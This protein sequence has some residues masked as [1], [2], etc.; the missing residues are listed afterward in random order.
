MKLQIRKFDYKWVV[1]IVCFL[2]N[3]VCLGFT[4]HRSLYLDAITK[5][6][7]FERSL[8]ALNETFRYTT[9]AVIN[10][11]FGGLLQRIGARK[12]IAGG[13][14]ML[15]ASMV[16]A[17]WAETVAMFYV[18]GILLGIGYACTTTT[19]TGSI[20]RRWFKKD[21]GRYTGI[22]LAAN[23]IG[24]A[25]S[26]QI[27]SPLISDEANPFG[28]RNAYLISAVFI[29]VAGI[30]VLIFLRER[31][32]NEELEVVTTG[33]KRR[34][35]SWEGIPL[36]TALRRPY[37]YV[38]AVIVF[39]TGFMLQ[40]I[41]GVYGTHLKD[42]GFDAGVVATIASVYS[43]TLTISKITVGILYDR[44]GL[45]FVMVLCQGSAAISLV[46]LVVLAVTPLGTAM[47][48][49]FAVLYAL[50]LP[51]E[52]LVIPLIVSELFG[53]ASFDK[54]F[55]VFAALNYAGYAVSAP[56]VNLCFDLTDSYNLIFLLFSGL[57]VVVAVI[58]QLVIGTAHKERR[59]LE[60]AKQ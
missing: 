39:L 32:K 49:V 37:F 52:T 5:A 28:Y 34:G 22:A 33:K 38:A 17:A 43:L 16:V 45:R 19:I 40:G 23:G 53:S 2:M 51:L 27:I 31:P 13:F 60:A 42:V 8:F 29:A 57:T 6:L 56:I 24:G 15:F 3:F 48:F 36:K 7:G 41:G 59:K 4:T 1:L 30:L 20:I 58:V 11:F 25:V 26:A 35:V 10:L 21:I 12:M 50:S 54:L 46:L 18:S 9:L 55:G 44:F 47:A 14:V